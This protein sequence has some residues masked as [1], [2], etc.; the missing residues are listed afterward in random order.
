MVRSAAAAILVLA[1]TTV[2][3]SCSSH[4]GGAASCPTGS[5]TCG[6][7]GNKT[8]NSGLT[9]ASNVCVNLSGSGSGGISGGGGANGG[10]SGGT[11]GATSGT[12]G[13]PSGAGGATSGSGGAG[14]GSGGTNGGSGGASGCTCT[15]GMECTTDGHC[16]DPNV[17]DD[18]ADCNTTVNLIR[19]RNGGW[20]AAADVGVNVSFA[21]GTPP[22]GYSD[23]QCGAWTNGGPTGNGTTYW[24]LLGVA[25][26]ANLGPVDLSGYR[27]ITVALE[28]Q[29]VDFTI[30]LLNGG[31]F[32]RRLTKTAGLQSFN[33]DFSSLLPRSDSTMSVPNWANV[34][35]IQFT[36]IDPSVG[37]G[38]VIHGLTL[39]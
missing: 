5:E 1:V 3:V 10:T 2:E 16:V 6:C 32:T 38:F 28:A 15:G 12:G 7:Y 21:V 20:Y 26:K 35:D 33:V 19:G 9:C 37:Y 36:V 11:G 4:D 25:L 24:A 23:R 18:F 17:I 13:S 8:C 27:G 14:T 29:A 39:Y 30:K 34:T 22:S 31:Y